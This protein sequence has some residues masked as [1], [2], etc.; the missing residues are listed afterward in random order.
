MT[1]AA[2][3]IIMLDHHLIRRNMRPLIWIH[4]TN[5]HLI[6]EEHY[7]MKRP[8]ARRNSQ[9]FKKLEMDNKLNLPVKVSLSLSAKVPN[10]IN[11]I[12]MDAIH[13]LPVFKHDTRCQLIILIHQNWENLKKMT[14]FLHILMKM[15]M[16][17]VVK[18]EHMIKVSVQSEKYVQYDQCGPFFQRKYS[19]KW[20]ESSQTVDLLVIMEISAI[21][22]KFGKLGVSHRKMS[23]W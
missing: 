16:C 18:I 19:V 5:K 9:N 7:I 2:R 14:N 1:D 20:W 11:S 17:F 8:W 21:T 23:N 3:E 4:N 15:A 10:A 22:H 6:W 12:H 13:W